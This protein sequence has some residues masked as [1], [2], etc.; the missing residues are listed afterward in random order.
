MLKLLIHI[1]N[2]KITIQAN[3]GSFVA[4]KLENEMK[5]DQDTV[6]FEEP[7]WGLFLMVIVFKNNSQVLKLRKAHRGAKQAW[8]QSG[9]TTLKRFE[10]CKLK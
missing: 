4:K 2:W 6:W 3:E 9:M 10:N 1:E 7:G 8:G 5:A